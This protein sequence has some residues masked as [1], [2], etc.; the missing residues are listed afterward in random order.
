[1][2][3]SPKPSQPSKGAKAWI[4]TLGLVC[5]GLL[6]WFFVSAVR[7]AQDRTRFEEV[8]KQKSLIA[9]Q[10]AKTLGGNV[11]SIREQDECFNAEQ[12]PWDHGNLWCQVATVIDLKQDAELSRVGE[13]FVVIAQTAGANSHSS[14]S[15]LAARFW[16][17]GKEGVT[18]NLIAQD[19]MGR[20]VGGAT[21][22][23]FGA[24]A[25]PAVAITCADR[26]RAAFYPYNGE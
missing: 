21:S 23:P 25:K 2:K 22:D 20:E 5:I 17:V 13:E 26:A 14:G 10:L 16:Y 24:G 19:S 1:M 18:C 11:V 6:V 3:K 4:V 15:G 9:S 7:I 12:G 8:S